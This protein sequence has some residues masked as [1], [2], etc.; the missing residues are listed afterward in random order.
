MAY[1]DE[2]GRTRK[3]VAYPGTARGDSYCAR[4]YGIKKGMLADGGDSAKKARDPDSPNN[5]RR[6]AWKCSGKKSKG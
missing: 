5:K 3:H 4:S 1:K 2:S 6:K